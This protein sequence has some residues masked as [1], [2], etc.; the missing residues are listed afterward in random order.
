MNS[1]DAESGRNW[2]PTKHRGEH[3]TIVIIIIIKKHI[4]IF[5]LYNI[6]CFLLLTIIIGYTTILLFVCMCD[7]VYFPCATVV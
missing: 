6:L 5:L 7:D 2:P 4:Y 1:V 3:V